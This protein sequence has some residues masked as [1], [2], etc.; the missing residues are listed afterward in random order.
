MPKRTP[1]SPEEFDRQLAERGAD[2]ILS[3]PS[4][5]T[6]DERILYGR[7][8]LTAQSGPGMRRAV[9]LL[10]KSRDHLAVGIAAM[11]CAQAKQQ[12][13]VL[14]LPVPG[15]SPA[16]RDLDGLSW[17]RFARGITLAEQGKVMDAQ[18]E[19]AHG[20]AAACEAGLPVRAQ[21]LRQ[22]VRWAQSTHGRSDL[23]ALD[24]MRAEVMTDM[25]RN[26]FADVGL[27]GMLERGQYQ[28]A[29]HF[30]NPGSN[31]RAAA[32]SL[33]GEAGPVPHGL[34]GS[35]LAARCWQLAWEG[36]PVP[37]LTATRSAVL[38]GYARLAFGAHLSR[39]LSGARL[40]DRVIGAEAPA[41]ADQAVLWSAV[42]LAALG[43]G[44][45]LSDPLE[46]VGTLT[47]AL[48]QLDSTDDVL[49][50]LARVLPEALIVASFAPGAHAEAVLAAHSVLTCPGWPSLDVQVRGLR[51]EDVPAQPGRVPNLGV[52]IRI[53]DRLVETAAEQGRVGLERHWQLAQEQ[54]LFDHGA[55]AGLRGVTSHCV[56]TREGVTLRA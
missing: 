43:R 53:M 21:L 16:R 36:L 45:T 11:L 4:P 34:K 48:S 35:A 27:S 28:Q 33:I 55:R 22:H 41:L 54:L 2:S 24:G 1:W 42:G 56:G 9:Q 18:I 19:L 15:Y 29:A 44:A 20:I 5:K 47:P 30:S 13:A 50:L 14:D 46:T 3:G 6:L 39:T 10:A 52:V 26:W 38:D 7:A 32:L 37:R 23:D 40:V 8:A 49:A 25:R 31:F 12:V 17:L 51:G